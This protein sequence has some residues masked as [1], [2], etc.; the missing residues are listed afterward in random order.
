MQTTSSLDGLG[1]E[2]G[3]RA[4]LWDPPPQL[5]KPSN[6]FLSPQS[7]SEGTFGGRGTRCAVT[8]RIYIT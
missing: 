8:P 3:M 6:A 1:V 4:A 7:R 5:E 2:V